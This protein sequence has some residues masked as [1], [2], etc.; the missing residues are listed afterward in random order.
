MPGRHLHVPGTPGTF[1][2]EPGRAFPNR[3]ICTKKLYKM[4]WLW[5]CNINGCNVPLN[6]FNI[7]ISYIFGINYIGI[8]ILIIYIA[9]IYLCI[10]INK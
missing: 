1:A 3:E 9:L 4:S 5:L 6:I 2:L 8:N 7:V 10:F